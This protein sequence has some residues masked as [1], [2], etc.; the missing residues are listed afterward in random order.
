MPLTPESTRVRSNA[1]FD[2][3]GTVNK[4]NTRVW[5]KFCPERFFRSNCTRSIS[6]ADHP[7][8]L[9]IEKRMRALKMVREAAKVVPKIEN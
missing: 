3:K 9:N 8:W 6:D 1:T 5:F 2:F 4:M 7:R